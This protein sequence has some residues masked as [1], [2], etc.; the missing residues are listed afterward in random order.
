VGYRYYD[1]YK[2]KPMY[3]FGYGLSYTN[4]SINNLKIS[5]PI[6]NGLLTA[7]VTVK[8]TGKVA[9]K[10]VVQVYISAPTKTIDKPAQELKAFGK[11]RLLQPGE[12]Q[13]LTFKINAADLASFHTDASSWITD[14][15]SYVLKAGAS[16]RDIRQTADFKVLKTIVVEKDHNVLK[17]EVAIDEYKGK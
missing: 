11:T 6:F 2:V 16:S 12:S 13:I 1:T 3:E 15:G 7:T 8:N 14:A 9:G 5:S 4:F 10:E 17:P